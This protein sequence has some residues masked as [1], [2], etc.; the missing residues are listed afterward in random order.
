MMNDRLGCHACN[1]LLRMISSRL[2]ERVWDTD[3]IARTGGDEFIVVMESPIYRKF[4]EVT[5]GKMLDA[6]TTPFL[7]EGEPIVVDISIGTAEFPKDGFTSDT[8]IRYVGRALYAAKTTGG[9][10][11]CWYGASSL[12]S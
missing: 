8:L 11:M 9:Q 12:Y 6:F 5:A 1:D 3:T 7:I 4:V 10:Q 2:R